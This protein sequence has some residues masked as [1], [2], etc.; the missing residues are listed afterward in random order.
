[1]FPRIFAFS[2]VRSIITGGC[3]RE[4]VGVRISIGLLRDF[5]SAVLTILKNIEFINNVTTTSKSIEV[6]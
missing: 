4:C 2:Y 5:G 3:G 1:M 6:L